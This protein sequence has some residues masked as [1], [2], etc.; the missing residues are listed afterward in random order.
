ML[1]SSVLGRLGCIVA[2]VSVACADASSLAG[3]GGPGADAALADAAGA[4]RDG[5]VPQPDASDAGAADAMIDAGAF[6]DQQDA[7]LFL[8]DLHDDFDH[9]PWG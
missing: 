9:G 5:S 3:G 4:A 2:A 8:C 7:A 1:R 6:C